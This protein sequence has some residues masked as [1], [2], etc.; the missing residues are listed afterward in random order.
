MINN[1][2]ADE[3]LLKSI[4]NGDRYAFSLLYNRHLKDLHSYVYFACG[5]AEISAD[6][7]QELFL[8]V[9]EEKKNFEKITCFKT[10]IF[11]CAKNKVIDHLRREKVKMLIYEE[12]STADESD[13][14][15][16]DRHLISEECREMVNEA[17]SLLPSKRRQILLLKTEQELSLDEIAVNL[18]ISKSVV[19]K[20][21]YRGLNF[22]KAYMSSVYEILL[23]GFILIVKYIS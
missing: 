18:A 13:L 1:E 23:F 11:R 10:Y 7:L 20:Q 6:I 4:A 14:Y 8:K 15:G 3:V 21:L 22:V 2:V 5:N 12:I 19:K 16:A 9:W 17:I